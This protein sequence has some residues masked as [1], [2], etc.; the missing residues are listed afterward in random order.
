MRVLG[1]SAADRDSTRLAFR[2]ACA[3]PGDRAAAYG[4][5]SLAPVFCQR[6]SIQCQADPIPRTFGNVIFGIDCPLRQLWNMP[7]PIISA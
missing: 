6:V 7:N 1:T 5:G 2:Q 3:G 4:G